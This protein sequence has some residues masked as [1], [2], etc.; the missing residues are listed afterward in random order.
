MEKNLKRDIA[1]AAADALIKDGMK[2]GLGTGS[3]ACWV[4]VRL[5]ELMKAKKV[6][7]IHAVATSYN[8]RLDCE[9]L[10]IPL[11]GLADPVLANS[12]DLTIDG[13]DEIDPHRALIKGGGGA[14]LLEKIIAYASVEFAIVATDSKLVTHLGQTF[15]VPVEVVPEALSLVQ[16]K[17][18]KRGA[19][20]VVL[21]T[22]PN[23]AGPVYTDHG[24]LILDAR[25]PKILDPAA[26]ER[27]L[28][29]IPGVV[30]SGVFNRPVNHLFIGFPDGRVERR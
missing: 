29:S 26:L 4:A 23:F 9:R 19:S 11:T 27:E 1:Y 14:L 16:E 20:P 18:V 22:P 15:A 7:S 17:L 24:N 13:A 10:G 30:E 28:K 5:S 25:F 6:R 21:R 12:L 8:T 2:L 3:T